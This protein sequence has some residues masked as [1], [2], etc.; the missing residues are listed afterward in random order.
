[1]ARHF[2]TDPRVKN[3]INRLCEQLLRF[4]SVSSLVDAINYR[5]EAINSFKLYPNRLHS[6]L[7]EEPNRSINTVT[8]CAIEESLK[9][10]ESENLRYDDK[11]KTR[12]LQAISARME[13]GNS[14]N[15]S[16]LKEISDEFAMPFAVVQ[17]L[18]ETIHPTLISNEVI[19]PQK[20][21]GKVPD[22]SWQKDAVEACLR[23]LKKGT[24]NKAGLVIPT[25]G[26]KTRVA[27]EIILHWL[28]QDSRGD[29]VVLWVTHRKRLSQQARR[30]LQVLLRSLDHIPKESTSL[31]LKR[32]NFIM[33]GDLNSALQ[34]FGDRVSLIT[35]DEA[36]HAAA[37]SY[38]PILDFAKPVLFLTATPN[39][40]DN[41]PIGID[42][43]AYTITYRELFSRGC[44]I[45]PIFEPPLNILDLDWNSIDGLKSL[46]EY[47][48]KKSEFDFG[49]ILVAVS[50]QDRASML[51]QAIIR[52]LENYPNHPL[53]YEDVGY[54]HGSGC[55]NT[56]QEAN[57][58]LDEFVAKPKGILV[59]TS[60]LVGEGFND[61]AIDAVVVT[62][63][64]TS[65]SHLMQVAGRALRWAPGKVQAHIVQVRDSMLQYY[66]DQRWLYQ[67]ISDQL[68]PSL[69]DLTYKDVDDLLLTITDFLSSYHV[70]EAV[71]ERIFTELKVISPGSEVRM[72]LTGIPY[73]GSED[74]FDQHAEWGAILLSSEEHQRFLRIFNDV[75][76]RMEDVKEQSSYLKQFITPDNHTGSLWK[77]YVDLIS[78][79]EYA[80]RE[81]NGVNYAG[82]AGRPFQ[83]GLSTTWLRYV[84]F[85]YSAEVPQKLELFLGD[86]QNKDE[87]I[88]QY[89]TSTKNWASILKLEMP[90]I[91]TW[92]YLLNESQ[93]LWFNHEVE[94]LQ[95]RL[96]T[97]LGE[98]SFD[99]VNSW[100]SSLPSCPIPYRIVQKI[101]Q[102]ININRFSKQYL[103]L[104]LLKG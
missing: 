10:L 43:V 49:K 61:P 69:I 15:N 9:K 68:R 93:D 23:S 65:I 6:L 1:M 99:E 22:W 84:T 90:L 39:R 35:V 91:G 103:N 8:L 71:R 30:E 56:A 20:T 50:M 75:S 80:R 25:G 54:V 81:I 18:Y 77:S 73:F 74:K 70:P 100:R 13:K 63:P 41:L 55:S 34:E 32:I 57:E 29:S 19:I 46:A 31:F 4:E 53:D 85:K 5:I 3:V 72:M 83:R 78:A 42:E 97:I 12:I 102:V 86:V 16:V 24:G 62:Y 60:Q 36:H 26:G 45:E 44:V 14:T 37:P 11:L 98:R 92:A 67:D 7:S 95:S 64:S 79:M 59:A 48:L 87:I 76:W 94:R 66:F 27:L 82:D 28:E 17:Y 101:D 88:I 21:I 47:L 104:I 38:A 51:Y 58:F 2:R 40:S 96:Q 33:V 52:N 89:L